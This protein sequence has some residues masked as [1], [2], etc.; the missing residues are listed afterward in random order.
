VLTANGL[1]TVARNTR[2]SG[3]T[4][5]DVHFRFEAPVSGGTLPPL[6]VGYEIAIDPT[7]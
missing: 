4:L 6:S 1:V 5:Q 2:G 7:L 3:E